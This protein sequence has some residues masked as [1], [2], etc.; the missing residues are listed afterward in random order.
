MR[1]SQK[2]SNQDVF[3]ATVFGDFNGDR[4]G[5]IAG[6]HKDGRWYVSTSEETGLSTKAFGAWS[7]AV[8]W[9]REMTA[10]INGDGRADI[11]GLEGANW[12][13][14]VSTPTGFVNYNLGRWPGDAG[15]TD[16][17]IGD[18]NGDKKADLIWRSGNTFYAG[19]S[20]GTSL[21]FVT[22]ATW[23]AAVTWKDARFPDFNGDGKT[24]I[25]ARENGGNWWVGNSQADGC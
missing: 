12:W 15:V 17:G 21:R 3:V 16:I 2:Q 4:R 11:I 25:I 18:V 24:D 6:R 22:L 5:D 1:S 13:A 14:A 10:D 7:P 9:S 19:V 23:S 8:T 20:N